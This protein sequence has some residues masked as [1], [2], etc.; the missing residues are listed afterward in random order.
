[1]LKD[2]LH[3]CKIQKK[4]LRQCSWSFSIYEKNPTQKSLKTKKK[5]AAQAALSVKDIQ[6]HNVT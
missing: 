4:P 5:L 1:M 3:L 2:Q 6:K